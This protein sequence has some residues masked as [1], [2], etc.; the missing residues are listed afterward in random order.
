[1]RRARR[2]FRAPLTHFGSRD[3]NNVIFGKTAI[4]P[5]FFK[6][7]DQ[8]KTKMIL[9]VISNKP[10]HKKDMILPKMGAKTSFKYVTKV[11]KM[12]QVYISVT[13]PDGPIVTI[14]DR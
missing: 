3:V 11:T 5:S 9:Y 13:V 1:M 7:K 8:V 12:L 14:I 6:A 2:H 4:T 10:N